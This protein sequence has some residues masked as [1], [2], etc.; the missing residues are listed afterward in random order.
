ME[1]PDVDG[2]S[3]GGPV[4]L[5]DEAGGGGVEVPDVEIPDAGA[6]ELDVPEP[7]VEVSEVSAAAEEADS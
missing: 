5:P 1:I 7:A 4:D 6:V 2:E 3:P